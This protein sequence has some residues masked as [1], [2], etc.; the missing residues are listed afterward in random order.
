M[1]GSPVCLGVAPQ[2]F[3]DKLEAKMPS[4]LGSHQSGPGWG[5]GLTSGPVLCPYAKLP[6]DSKSKPESENLGT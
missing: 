4:C 2:A 5:P 1:P 3:A 6:L